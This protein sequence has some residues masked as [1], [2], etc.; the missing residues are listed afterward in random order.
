MIV[1]L[2]ILTCFS[3]GPPGRSGRD[4]AVGREGDLG[5]R[6]PTGVPGVDGPVVG[7]NQLQSFF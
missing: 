5:E 7:W 2:M 6:G 1:T 3:Q 4:G